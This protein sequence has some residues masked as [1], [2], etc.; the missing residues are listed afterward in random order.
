LLG[1]ESIVIVMDPPTVWAETGADA[2]VTPTAARTA[3]AINS[4]RK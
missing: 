3:V 2:P 1:G 4:T